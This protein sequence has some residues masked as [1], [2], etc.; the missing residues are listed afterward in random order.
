MTNEAL[1]AKIEAA[2][3][4]QQREM[5]ELAFIAIHGLA[6][7]D[8][9]RFFDLLNAKAYESA[10]ITLVPEGWVRGFEEWPHPDKGPITRA[11]LKETSIS[12][13]G[14]DTIWGHSSDD[15]H[16][17]GKASTPALALA[18]ACVRAKGTGHE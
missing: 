3:A 13:I 11:W 4:E 7:E 9:D 14:G 10:A 16:I 2:P 5:L 6:L 8:S 17:E 15:Q 12:R 18:A 1:A